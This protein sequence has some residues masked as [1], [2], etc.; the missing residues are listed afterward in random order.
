MSNTQ[1]SA[2][3]HCTFM[4]HWFWKEEAHLGQAG[5]PGE[6]R[7][8]WTEQWVMRRS[9]CLKFKL[10]MV[11]LPGERSADVKNGNLQKEL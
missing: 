8:L 2:W 9:D 10:E 1:K 11:S 3:C 7:G 4:L 6:S 5:G